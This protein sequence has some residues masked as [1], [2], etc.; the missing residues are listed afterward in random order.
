M[1]KINS[2]SQCVYIYIYMYS[3]GFLVFLIFFAFYVLL[4]FKANNI[5]CSVSFVLVIFFLNRKN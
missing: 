2:L 3:V 1:H 4:V 5:K